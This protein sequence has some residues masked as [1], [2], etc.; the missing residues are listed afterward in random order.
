MSADGKDLIP[1]YSSLWQT[2]KNNNQYE[3]AFEYAQKEYE[4]LK[5]NP[6]EVL[7]PLII[8]KKRKQS[9]N[10]KIVSRHVKL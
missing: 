5:D 10:F 1:I 7:Y 6:A 2:Y 4:L 8:H 3:E 9:C